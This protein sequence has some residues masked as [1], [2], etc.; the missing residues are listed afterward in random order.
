MVVGVVVF[1]V[2]GFFRTLL[3]LQKKSG[4]VGAPSRS[5]LAAHSSPSTP[6]AYG[7]VR[8]LEELAQEE[9]KEEQKDAHVPDSTE[10]V[11]L[12]DDTCRTYYW[13]RRTRTTKWK[14]PP[15]IRVVWVAQGHP[16]Q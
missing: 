7:M 5:E 14:P 8:A 4:K 12:C 16:C 6:G 3:C 2:Q 15:G 1:M 10:W 13:N 11:Q 9:E